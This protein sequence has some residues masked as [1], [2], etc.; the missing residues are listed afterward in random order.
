MTGQKR[1][2]N[3]SPTFLGG[4]AGGLGTVL[5]SG[6]LTLFIQLA[7]APNFPTSAPFPFVLGQK[8]AG[9]GE[10]C[11]CTAISSNQLTIKRAQEGTSAQAWPVG[12]PIET[13]VTAATMNNLLGGI[14]N[15][16]DYGADRSGVADSTSAFAN[17]FT[18][19]SATPGGRV[20]APMGFYLL[21]S[22]ET[23]AGTGVTLFGDGPNATQMIVSGSF[24]GSSLFNITGNYCGI[25]D[26]GITSNTHTS[27]SNPAM[28]GIEVSGAQY[29]TLQNLDIAYVNGW[30]IEVSSSSLV[31][32]LGSQHH[33]IH[34]LHCAGGIH[35]L[36]NNSGSNNF[37]IQAFLSNINAEIVDGNT[38]SLDCFLFEDSNDIVAK[39]LIGAAAQGTPTNK[40]L[41]IKGATTGVF[42]SNGDGGVFPGAA[43]APTCL[44]ESGTNGT[45]KGV[46]IVNS[47]FQAGTNC[48]SVTAGSEIHVA[49]TIFKRAT[50]HGISLSGTSTHLLFSGCTFD[51]NNQAGAANTYDVTTSS[52]GTDIRFDACDFDAAIGS[53]AGQVQQN[54][55]ITAGKVY[56]TGSYMQG[57]T[58][59]GYNSAN[60]APA[61]IKN[62]PNVNP[63]GAFTVSVP[64]SG[65]AISQPYD[66]WVVINALNTLTAVTLNATA[67]PGTPASGSAYFVPAGVTIKLTYGGAAPTWQWFGN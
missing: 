58:A 62:C 1:F 11:L 9:L 23:I 10:I 50:T 61:W 33:S 5:N 30:A 37:G 7:A 42:V 40:F 43:S 45:P 3:F 59:N 2:S 12:T 25:R 54:L 18:A 57:G 24:S 32:S 48:M 8:I 64:A 22:T 27:S 41:H 14:F 66:S 34:I 36:G 60:T 35:T 21:S 44:I 56:V 51:N 26:L 53:A 49:N 29:A 17:A 20:Y 38:S 4:G 16:L 31:Q 46:E 55:N 63:V 39:N 65:T 52:T 13:D 15:V 28:N 47:I 6:D 67:V 19:A